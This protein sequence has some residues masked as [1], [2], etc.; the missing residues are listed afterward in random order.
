M[1]SISSSVG[2][3]LANET[4]DN[5]AIDRLK[6]FFNINLSSDYLL[7][8]QNLWDSF[9]KIAAELNYLRLFVKFC[10][11]TVNYLFLNKI[12]NFYSALSEY[13]LIKK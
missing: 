2:P 3:Q 11:L 1:A 4:M 6:I 12:F 13:K 10:N 8:S 9:L 7:Y 5:A